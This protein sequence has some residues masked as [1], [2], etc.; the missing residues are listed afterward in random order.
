MDVL[1]I[2]EMI[3]HH[4]SSAGEIL[5]RFPIWI[6]IAG[7]IVLEVL[8]GLFSQKKS[9]VTSSH[10]GGPQDIRWYGKRNIKTY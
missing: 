9:T 7:Y 1:K 8:I 5:G 4:H 2:E 10:I 3:H 6:I